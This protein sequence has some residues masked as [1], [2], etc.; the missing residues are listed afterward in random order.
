M[1][2]DELLVLQIPYVQHGNHLVVLIDIQ[3]VLDSPTLAVLAFFGNLESTQPV[4]LAL[5]GK[6]QQ[7]VVVGAGEDMLDEVGVAGRRAFGALASPTL[8][9]VFTQRGTF[10]VA[11]M[12]DGDHHGVVGDHI[13]DAELASSGNDLGAALVTIFIFDF[14]KFVFDNLELHVHIL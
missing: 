13:L 5:F 11:E 4:A 14:G 6:E 9:A 10:H 12:R 8:A 2:I 7:V 3:Q 1:V